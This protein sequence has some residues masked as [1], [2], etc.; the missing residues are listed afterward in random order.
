MHD[1]WMDGVLFFMKWVDVWVDGYGVMVLWII[2]WATDI[3]EGRYGC[4]LVNGW[5]DRLSSM[6]GEMHA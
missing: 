4:V 1:D 2:V 6:D 5:T 3:L